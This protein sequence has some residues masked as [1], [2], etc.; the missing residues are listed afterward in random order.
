MTR[1]RH[2]THRQTIQRIERLRAVVTALL[3]GDL[4]GPELAEVLGLSPAG[5]RKYVRELSGAGIIALAV[6]LD[7]AVSVVRRVFTLAVTQEQA[8]AYLAD[9]TVTAPIRAAKPSKSAMSVA[10]RDSTRHVHLMKHD[11]QFSIRLNRTPPM[12]DPLVAA[13]FGAGVHEVRA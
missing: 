1:A 5:S 9:L 3:A 7:G 11:V 10:M 4:P 8:R 6:P 2:V 12:R 13:F